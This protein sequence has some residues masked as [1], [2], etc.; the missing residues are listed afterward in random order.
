VEI[1]VENLACSFGS[2]EAVRG[3]SFTVPSGTIT[4]L[5]GPSGCGKTTILRSIAGLNRP[6]GGVIRFGERTVFSDKANI[7]VPPEHRGLGMIFQ[8]FALW[9]H[10][11]VFDNV[12][13][14]LRMRH[15]NRSTVRTKVMA[16]LEMVHLQDES[17]RF[18]HQLSGGQ[19]QRVA[20][21]R[22]IVSEPQL[23]LLD[24]PLSSLD[25]GLREEMRHELAHLIK[26]L[27]ITAVHVT[28]DHVEALSM[29]SRIIVLNEGRIEQSGDP[30]DIYRN[31]RNLFVARFLGVVNVMTGTVE[32]DQENARVSGAGWSV[33]GRPHG[34]LNSHG[35]ALIRPAAI[36]VLDKDDE[37]SGNQL[38]V[39]V[40][41]GAFHG[42][43]W[44]FEVASESGE[45]FKIQTQEAL[46]AGAWVRI[47]FSVDACRVIP[48]SDSS[49]LEAAP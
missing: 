15:M 2:K 21:A 5:L 3:V 25:A 49:D 24:E 39:Q 27:G 14:G 33:V 30:V 47:H 6:Q 23:L 41:D 13:F 22:A 12:A 17:N 35:H 9:P 29:A 26:R 20:V 28:H 44:Q 36:R 31:P 45:R 43:R 38:T 16:A 34:L 1:V 42:D 48:I 32:P 40:L 7:N 8:D 11:R 18:P 46:L 19:Q 10:M 37:P 4:A